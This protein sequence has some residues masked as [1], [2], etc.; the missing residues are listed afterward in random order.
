MTSLRRI[1]QGVNG[2]LE[3]GVNTDFGNEVG[4]VPANLVVL[5]LEQYLVGRFFDGHC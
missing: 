1:N 3:V 5:R 4:L 2:A